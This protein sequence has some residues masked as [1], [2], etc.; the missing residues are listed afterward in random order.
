MKSGSDVTRQEFNTLANRVSVLEA[1]VGLDESRIAA[2]E[3]YSLDFDPI[4]MELQD[5]VFDLNDRVA[6]L[7]VGGG[8]DPGIPPDTNIYPLKMPANI[9]PGGTVDIGVGPNTLML[10]LSSQPDLTALEC[11]IAVAVDGKVVAGPLRISARTGMA[12]GQR[13]YIRGSWGSRPKTIQFYSG[14]EVGGL[15]LLWLNEASYD[16]IPLVYNGP[17]L[18]ARGALPLPNATNLWDNIGATFEMSTETVVVV[19][20]PPPP[21]EVLSDII[22]NGKTLAELVDEAPAG[23]TLTLPAGMFHAT[24]AVTKHLTI[25]GAGIGKTTL[26]AAGMACA[27]GKGL[28]VAASD[29]VLSDMTLTGASVPDHNGAGVRVEPNMSLTMNRVEV[30]GCENGILSSGGTGIITENECYFHENGYGAGAAGTHE[31]YV[32]RDA[33][34]TATNSRYQ[35]GDKSTHAFKSRAAKVVLTGCSFRGSTEMVGAVAGSVVDLPDG[36]ALDMI[37]CN[38]ISVP[39][40]PNHT[41]IGYALESGVQGTATVTLQDVHVSDGSGTG[42]KIQAGQAGAKLV[43]KGNCTYTGTLPPVVEGW[44]SVTGQF[45]PA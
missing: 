29:L 41:L 26:T 28:F 27:W 9:P 6:A 32:G 23:S 38:V 17:S 14:G 25:V 35:A 3:D 42:G 10:L 44:A 39:G 12:G 13:F 18:D 43:I 34:A 40:A 33:L 2:L 21:P 37:S 31:T 45:V 22:M 20:P 30:F 24:V 7:E 8:G 36:G 4:I 19:P 11:S 15:N 5:A 16:F 1:R